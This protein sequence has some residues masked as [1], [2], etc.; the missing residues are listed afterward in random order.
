MLQLLY[1]NFT[2]RR[3][4]K[5][6]FQAWQEQT[7]SALQAA[8]ANPLSFLGDSIVRFMYPDNPEAYPLTEKEVKEVNY[9][10]V[11]QLYRSRFANARG[12]NFYF[13]GNIDEAK[14]RPLVEQYIASLPA[15]KT[16][17]DKAYYE[18]QKLGRLGTHT[19]EYSAEM[20]T[21]T[22][23]VLDGLSIG[24]VYELQP[25]LTAEVLSGILDQLYV[26]T[27]REEEGG[28]Y[29]VSVN[30][31]VSR[32][33]VVRRNLL[34]QFQ[35]DPTKAEKLNGLVF[36][37]LEGIAADGPSQEHFD[38]TIA[39]LKKSHAENLRKNNYWLTKLSQYFADGLD[40]VTPYDATL[41][42]VRPQDVQQLV[43]EFTMTKDRRVII[44]RSK[45]VTKK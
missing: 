24:G 29:G 43:K 42:R 25:L 16:Y 41:E 26:K 38:K 19:K 15:Q 27:I 36:K 31:S 23:I 8:K 21:P 4:D 11:L 9:E 34:V 3:A 17:T 1:L 7:I 2:A 40:F 14:F 10:R 44:F 22:G 20:A 32:H 28:T 45:E 37:G 33:P 39:N 18:R 30:V 35:T 6:A 12:F 5:E 13:V